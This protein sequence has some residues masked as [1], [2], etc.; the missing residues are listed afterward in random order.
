MKPANSKEFI[1]AIKDC[2]MAHMET[3]CGGLDEARLKELWRDLNGVEKESIVDSLDQNPFSELHYASSTNRRH[4]KRI[5]KN[6]R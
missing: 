5:G 2:C 6:L 4:S 3:S 1:A